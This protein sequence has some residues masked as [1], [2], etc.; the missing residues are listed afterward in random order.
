MCQGGFE[1]SIFIS[2]VIF[3]DEKNLDC[4]FVNTEL[5]V[6]TDHNIGILLIENTKHFY[7]N[8]RPNPCTVVDWLTR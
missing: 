8:N 6:G 3:I 1:V 4:V 2:S 5:R 7:H